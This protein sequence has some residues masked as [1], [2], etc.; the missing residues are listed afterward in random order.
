MFETILIVFVI[1][2]LDA[3]SDLKKKSKEFLK[4]I[5][6]IDI[7]EFREI[8]LE[9]RIIELKEVVGED[10]VKDLKED[11]EEDLEKYLEKYL[12]KNIGIKLELDLERIELNNILEKEQEKH[13]ELSSKY[14]GFKQIEIKEDVL[15]KIDRKVALDL[16]LIDLEKK[17]ELGLLLKKAEWYKKKEVEWKKIEQKLIELR[18]E[19]KDNE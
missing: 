10:L 7:S 19:S 9:S 13:L 16:E 2:L 11:L 8:D 3:I 6:D 14:S 12:E 18:E 5:E 1:I 17:I 4:E 15:K